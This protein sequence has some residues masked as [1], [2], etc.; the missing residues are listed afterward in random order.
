[1]FTEKSKATQRALIVC[2]L[3]YTASMFQGFVVVQVYAEP[4]FAKAIPNLSPTISAVILGVVSVVAGF[5][6]AYFIDWFGRRVSMMY[7]D[8]YRR[9]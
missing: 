9:I 3:L 1:M 4:L 5:F 6:S 8:E 2:I 7:Y